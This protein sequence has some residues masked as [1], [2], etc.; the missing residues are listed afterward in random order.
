VVVVVGLGARV[1]RV[2]MA[3]AIS[4][5]PRY[6]V[7]GTALLPV[8]E[9]PGSCTSKQKSVQSSPQEAI[10]HLGI[11]RTSSS[12]WNGRSWQGG[13]PVLANAR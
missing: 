7:F 5:M 6:R 8:W 10:H 3:M 4:G 9:F 2:A 1:C 11:E 12:R 13:G